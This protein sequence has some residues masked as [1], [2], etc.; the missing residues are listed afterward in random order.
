MSVDL[1]SVLQVTGAIAVF[2]GPLLLL[3]F[4]VI[5][6]YFAWPIAS[7]ILRVFAT[8][9]TLQFVIG[10]LINIALGMPWPGSWSG[11]CSI[12]PPHGV[13]PAQRWS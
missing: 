8:V 4:Y 1:L 6:D 10:A 13:S 2:F 3:G 5:A 11:R 9:L 12:T 7:G